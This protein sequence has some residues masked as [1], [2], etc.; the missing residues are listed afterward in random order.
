MAVKKNSFLAGSWALKKNEINDFTKVT[1]DNR[2]QAI[3][4]GRIMYVIKMDSYSGFFTIDPC[5]TKG[6]WKIPF[7]PFFKKDVKHYRV[8][9][10]NDIPRV[11]WAKDFNS[12][13]TKHV[14]SGELYIKPTDPILTY[15]KE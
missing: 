8:Y 12:I 15:I 1:A 3:V 10:N 2:K 11:K 14:E 9:F 5:F 13:I 7:A 6:W 4:Q